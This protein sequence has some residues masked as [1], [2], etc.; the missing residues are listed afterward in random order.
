MDAGQSAM[1]RDEAGAMVVR[2]V[3]GPKTALWITRAEHRKR[4]FGPQPVVIAAGVTVVLLAVFFVKSLIGSLSEP[5]GSLIWA[6]PSF[7]VTVAVLLFVT[8]LII[9]AVHTLLE[10]RKGSP[11]ALR[12]ANPGAVLQVRY[13]DDGLELSTAIETVP[14]R[15]SEIRRLVAH[16]HTVLFTGDFGGRVLPRELFPPEALAYVQRSIGRPAGNR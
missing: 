14:F 6:D 1:W 11:R 12:Y 13:L 15:Y 9:F 4:W 3:A 8:V 16:K 2:C 5:G 10:M 7:T